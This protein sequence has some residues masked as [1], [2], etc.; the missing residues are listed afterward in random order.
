MMNPVVV[1]FRPGRVVWLCLA[2]VV[3]SAALTLVASG[4]SA[5]DDQEVSRVELLD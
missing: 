4:P 3:S 5:D 1:L 2:M